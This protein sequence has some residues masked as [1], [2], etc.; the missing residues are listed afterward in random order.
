M[1]NVR[2]GP[3]G[4]ILKDGQAVLS[5]DRT[6]IGDDGTIVSTSISGGPEPV[7]RGGYNAA[8]VSPLEGRNSNHSQDKL[9]NIR[10]KEYDI[11]MLEGRIR[12]AVPKQWI[13]ATIVLCAVGLMGVYFL[14][15]PAIATGIMIFVGFSK[16]RELEAE[17]DNMARELGH[18]KETDNQRGRGVWE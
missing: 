18:L 17:R 11:Q 5:D 12:N 2:I 8:P 9:Q 10:E 14:F 13:I 16:K 7:H 3:D 15:I 6:V 4:T 1:P